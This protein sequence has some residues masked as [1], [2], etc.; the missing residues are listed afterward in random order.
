M[1]DETIQ[2]DKEL[3]DLKEA[4]LSLQND[5]D[6]IDRLFHFRKLSEFKKKSL[7]NVNNDLYIW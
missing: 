3:Y 6:C 5:M 1:T 2:K 7:Q 4:V